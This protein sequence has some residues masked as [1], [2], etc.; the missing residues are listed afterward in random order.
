MELIP[1]KETAAAETPPKEK[2]ET[3]ATT[4]GSYRRCTNINEDDMKE[5]AAPTKYHWRLW[6]PNSLT[7]T[8]RRMQDQLKTEVQKLHQYTLMFEP[9]LG[10]PWKSH[11]HSRRHWYPLTDDLW[12]EKSDGDFRPKGF[13]G[14][15]GVMVVGLSKAKVSATGRR[16]SDSVSVFDGGMLRIRYCQT[17]WSQLTDKECSSTVQCD[18]VERGEAFSVEMYR[19]PL[20]ESIVKLMRRHKQCSLEELEQFVIGD[21]WMQR[22]IPKQS[23]VVYVQGPSGS[24]KTTL[25]KSISKLFYGQLVICSARH[26]STGDH[27]VAFQKYVTEKFNPHQY[28]VLIDEYVPPED[29][30]DPMVEVMREFIDTLPCAYLQINHRAGSKFVESMA[31]RTGRVVHKQMDP[32]TTADV[33]RM[34]RIM[35]G[36]NE[37]SEELFTR[38]KPAVMAEIV[39]MMNQCVTLDEL[40]TMINK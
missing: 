12:L 29:P 15:Q 19:T 37:V 11:P 26:L 8:V 38:W 2:D 40:V 36:E 25:A 5:E 4:I 28:A 21:Q 23:V 20:V 35:Y 24:G 30:N 18:G 3:A 34:A 10:I 9:P 6:V 16:I 27:V 31:F 14:F 17:N 39:T 13:G 32:P 33:M 1:P 7:L 22:S